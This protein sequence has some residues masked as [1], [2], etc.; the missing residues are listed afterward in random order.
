M[1]KSKAYSAHYL[2]V[3]GVGGSGPDHWQSQ[4]QTALVGRRVEQDDWH[5]PDLDRWTARLSQVLSESLYPPI[6]VAHS[7]GCLVAV[8]VARQTPERIAALFLAAPADPARFGIEQ[9]LPRTPVGVPSRLI[10]SENDP[11]LSLEN[12]RVWAGRWGSDFI[13][14]GQVGHI[15]PAS[16]HGDWPDGL[17]ALARLA[18][19]VYARGGTLPSPLA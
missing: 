14:A 1:R 8:E 17:R 19:P 15:N 16:G 7:F 13:N 5:A 6:V 18:R 2:I 4:W 10:A 12:A 11:W 9:R 3:P